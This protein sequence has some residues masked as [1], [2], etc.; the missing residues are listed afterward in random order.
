MSVRERG[1]P[2]RGYAD[3][4]EH[5]ALLEREGLLVRVKRPINK[6]TELH[7]LVRWQFRGGI[8]E[9]ERK[10]FLFEQVTDSKGRR[11]TMPVVVGALAASRRIYSLGIGAPVEQIGEKWRDALARPIPPELVQDGP[12]HEVV[13]TGSALDEPGGGLDLL[14]VPIST[15]GFDNAPYV[16]CAAWITKDPDTGAQNVGCYRAQLKARR[17]LGMNPSVELR[18]GIL[19]HWLKCRERGRP[20]P[21]ALMIGGP[22]VVS[23]TAVQ[24]LPPDVEELAV[25]GAL[26]GA[27]IR[28]VRCKTVDLTVPAEAEIVVEGF[29][30]TEWLEPEGPFGESHGHVNLQ[31][32]NPFME[33]T[34]ITYRRDAILPSI[35]S[36]VTPS[37][38]SLIKKVA[39]EPLL[40]H[41]LRNTLAIR[42]VVRVG[43][44]EPLTNLRKV[45]VVQM[46]QPPE[47]EVWQALYGI[48]SFQPA[49]GKIVIAVDEDIDPENPDAVLWALAYR[50]NPQHDVQIVKGRDPGHGPRPTRGAEAERDL[51]ASDSA[52]L[53]NAIRR[54]PLPPISLPKREYMERAKAIWEELGLP[55][56]KPESPWYGYS[57][58]EWCEEF[59][60]E[61][62]L[63]VQGD[64]FAVGERL[65]KRRIRGAMPNKGAWPG[66]GE[67]G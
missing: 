30:D 54:A 12:V 44:H 34:A 4:H 2:A 46:R 11:Y 38:S 37:E 51:S 59:E 42:S 19:T 67:A 10:A 9:P 3:L 33:V 63:A 55:P 64:A 22:P 49:I 16:S 25:A 48:V 20:L 31:E 52:M 56:L 5:L 58:G 15:P 60:E 40:L 53:I 61:A 24:K 1:R 23:Y 41:H 17:R 65:A 29:I 13:R 7:P 62:R 8:P 36:Q 21:A 14:P 39:Y 32:F 35:I 28:V 66:D 6:D 26:A 27:P 47:R 45:V 18:P 57:L 50:M 43:M